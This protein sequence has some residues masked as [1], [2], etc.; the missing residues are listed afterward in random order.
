VDPWRPVERA[1]VTHAHSDH[2][3]R[4]SGAYLSSAS[5]GALLRERLGPGALVEEVAFGRSV[6]INGV[7]VS[8]HPAGHILGSAQVRMEHRGEVWVVT[9]DY[10]R[11]PDPT[12]EA[13]EPLEAHTLVTECT[14]GLPIYRWPTPE[15]VMEEIHGWWR[16]NRAR[17][18]TSVLFAYALGKAQRILS[19]L[20]PGEGPILAHGA[21]LRL[22]RVYLASGR[23]QPPLRLADAAAARE[24]R[25]RGLVVAPPSA[26]VP[27]WLRKFGPVS[28]AFASGWMAVRGARRRRGADRGFPLSDHVDWADLLRTVKESGAER[29][30]ATH[31][32]G[33]ALV[34]FLAEELGLEAEALQE[35]PGREDE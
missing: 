25:G 2:A 33:S 16:E 35:R 3:R 8:L 28:T 26:G 4:G 15:S 9:G 6:R 29:V 19:L 34:R 31:G 24:C 1:V 13:F 27:G 10:K 17:G 21:V 7:G 5:G 12:A 23:V 18:R 32:Q 14:F 30:W 11:Q 22:S 20:D